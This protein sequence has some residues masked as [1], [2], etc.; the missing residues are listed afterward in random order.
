MT[1]IAFRKHFKTIHNKQKSFKDY[2]NF[3]ETFGSKYNL[4]IDEKTYL[5][6]KRL[7]RIAFICNHKNCDKKFAKNYYLK[8]HLKRHLS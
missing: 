8:N 2:E 6:H 3:N 5:G 1:S 4:K 7:E